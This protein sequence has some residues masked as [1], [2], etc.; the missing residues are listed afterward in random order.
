MACRYGI[1]L[2]EEELAYSEKYSEG[3]VF[4]ILQTMQ[5]LLEGEFITGNSR[6]SGII[7][8]SKN[9]E[10]AFQGTGG[11]REWWKEGT[12]V[13]NHWNPEPAAPDWR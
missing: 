4:A 11:S 2:A 6:V 1:E 12:A 8:K 3:N 7:E 13:C 9:F 10:A 5:R